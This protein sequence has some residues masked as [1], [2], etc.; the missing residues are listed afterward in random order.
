MSTSRLSKRTSRVRR[1]LSEETQTLANHALKSVDREIYDLIPGLV[2]VMDTDH[3]ILDLN[4]TAVRTA[5]KRRE[6]LRWRQV[7]G[8]VRQPTLQSRN[9]CRLRSRPDRQSL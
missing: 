6:D 3:T 8:L 1:N 7:L 5:G 4:E 2:I 9:L